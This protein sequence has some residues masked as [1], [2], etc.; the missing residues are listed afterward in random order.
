[1]RNSPFIDHEILARYEP[2][3][4]IRIEDVLVV[5]ETGAENLTVV[6]KDVDWLEAVAGGRDV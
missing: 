4:G 3:G 5:T 2:V 1:M 6:G